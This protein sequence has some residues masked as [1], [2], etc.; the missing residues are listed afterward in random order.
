M[1]GNGMFG[2]QLY[3]CDYRRFFRGS[4]CGNYICDR[5]IDAR[6]LAAVAQHTTGI[7]AIGMPMD[8]GRKAGNRENGNDND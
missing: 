4:R 5:I 3:F 8:K 1:D 2:Y 6:F 7:P